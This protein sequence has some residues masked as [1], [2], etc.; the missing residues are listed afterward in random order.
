LNDEGLDKQP[1]PLT[2]KL[3][4]MYFNYGDNRMRELKN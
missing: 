4:I 2:G 1:M 3:L